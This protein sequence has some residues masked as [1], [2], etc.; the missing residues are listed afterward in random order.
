MLALN[1]LCRSAVVKFQGLVTS[2]KQEV[3]AKEE[4]QILIKEE[5][6]EVVLVLVGVVPVLVEV[7][8]LVEVAHLVDLR[9]VVLVVVAARREEVVVEA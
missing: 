4:D 6:Q 3:L 2:L 1:N 9:E 8:H 5:A 7:V